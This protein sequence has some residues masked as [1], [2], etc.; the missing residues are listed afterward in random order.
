MNFRLPLERKE[1]EKMHK[2]LAGFEPAHADYKS[3]VLP[4]YDRSI[5][6]SRRTT[7]YPILEKMLICSGRL[8]C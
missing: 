2:L 3:A 8:W 6:P 1:N 4:L 7:F 5:T